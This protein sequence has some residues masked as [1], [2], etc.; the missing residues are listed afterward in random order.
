MPKR[1]RRPAF[2]STKARIETCLYAFRYK[3][4]VDNIKMGLAVDPGNADLKKQSSE[5][6]EI[7]RKEKVLS[8]PL[9]SHE[10][11]SLFLDARA[12]FASRDT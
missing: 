12:P 8:T 9:P 10:T 7:M 11:F 1:H 2:G 6:E 4:A 5:M 3:E